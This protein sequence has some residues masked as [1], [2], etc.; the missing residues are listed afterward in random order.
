MGLL[1]KVNHSFA[2]LFFFV[3]VHRV[4]CRHRTASH[5]GVQS[6]LDDAPGCIVKQMNNVALTF[7]VRMPSA[8]AIRS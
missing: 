4:L 2:V 8:D 5:D 1:A 3:A 7:G 6:S